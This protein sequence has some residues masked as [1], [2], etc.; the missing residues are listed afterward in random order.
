MYGYGE[1]LKVEDTINTQI[2]KTL[3]YFRAKLFFNASL[4]LRNRDRFVI[5]LKRKL[6]DRFHR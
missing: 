1:P 2:D 5:F 6:G 4:C 3:A